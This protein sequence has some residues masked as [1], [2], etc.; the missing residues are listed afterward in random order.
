MDRNSGIKAKLIIRRLYC[1]R[2]HEIHHELPDV[3]VPYKRYGVG[4]MEQVLDDRVADVSA[5]ESTLRRWRE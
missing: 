5:D 1:E 3:L 2:C 4:S